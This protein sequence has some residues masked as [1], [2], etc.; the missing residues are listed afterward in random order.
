MLLTANFD[1]THV[2][3]PPTFLGFRI[4]T[5]FS[6]LSDDVALPTFIICIIS[7]YCCH[8]QFVIIHQATSVQL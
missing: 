5:V 4:L 6:G 2:L 7:D 8:F 1:S 3:T